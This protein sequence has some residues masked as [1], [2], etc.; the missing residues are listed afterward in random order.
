MPSM[1]LIHI[2]YIS[3]PLEKMTGMY[4]V[5]PDGDGP[6]PTIYMLHGLSDDYTA[7]QRRTSIERYADALG[8]MVVLLDG[9]R[10]F[11]TDMRCGVG[12][13]EQHILASV[14]F[15]DRTFRTIDAPAARGIGGLSMGGYGAMKLGLKHPG[16]FGSVASHSGALDIAAT[17]AANPWPELRLIFGETL[18]PEDDLFAL[19]A[20]P[21]PKPSLYIDC[22][23][24]DFLLEHNRCFHAH[25]DRLRMAHVYREY[26]G[27]HDW[28]YWDAHVPAALRFHCDRFAGCGKDEGGDGPT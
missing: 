24:D 22:G 5:L 15:V 10:A 20:R 28:D 6:F 14:R 2:D 16:L 23:S 25:L 21:G 8:A 17:L 18:E 7:W 12:Q 1:S 13:Y 9:A 19:A 3:Q 4:V 26:P 11:Y 27:A